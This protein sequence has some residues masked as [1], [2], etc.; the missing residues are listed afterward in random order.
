MPVYTVSNARRKAMKKAAKKDAADILQSVGLITRHKSWSPQVTGINRPFESTV[1]KRNEDHKKI[2]TSGY[3]DFGPE[4]KKV[5]EVEAT[6]GDQ[7]M[8]E[9]L[10]AR[11]GGEHPIPLIQ[12]RS[13][14]KKNSGSWRRKSSKLAPMPIIIQ[15]E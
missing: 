13:T 7:L 9:R 5:A 12:T 3:T 14:T 11:M 2:Y 10:N 15:F 4:I 8:Q 1:R 6:A